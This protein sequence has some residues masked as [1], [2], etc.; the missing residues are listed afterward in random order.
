MGLC[1]RTFCI[2]NDKHVNEVRANT[3]VKMKWTLSPNVIQCDLV[4]SMSQKY[5]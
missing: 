4:V 2:T 3:V 1:Q 5:C